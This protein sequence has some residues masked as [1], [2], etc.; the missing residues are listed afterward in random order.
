MTPSQ[1]SQ[2]HETPLF[3]AKN[4]NAAHARIMVGYQIVRPKSFLAGSGIATNHLAQL[5]FLGKLS[6]QDI[7]IADQALAAVDQSLLRGDLAVGLNAE[8]KGGKQRVRN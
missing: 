7:E 1:D 2:P 4:P 6:A 3:Y 5:I 8:L